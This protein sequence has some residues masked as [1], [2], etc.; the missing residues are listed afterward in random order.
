M[1]LARPL[2]LSAVVVLGLS[3][4]AML[5]EAVVLVD[6]WRSLKPEEFLDWFGK[7]EPELVAFF[8]PLQTAGLLLTLLAVLAHAFP[9]REGSRL[10]GFSAAL[11]IA[12]LGLYV[13]YFK[14]VNAGFVARSISADEVP[15]EL[16]RWA[17]W[18]WA[19]TGIGIGAFVSALLAVCRTDES[20]DQRVSTGGADE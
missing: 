9:R 14:D 10:L 8:G 3:A 16:V 1:R 19:R 12:V 13:A 4:G 11:S 6:Y 5:T 20:L 17:N 2:A 15:A 18:Q 7:H